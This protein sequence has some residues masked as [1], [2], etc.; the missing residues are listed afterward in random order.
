MSVGL[1]LRKN[2]RQGLA[3]LVIPL[4]AGCQTAPYGG[5]RVSPEYS[6]ALDYTHS[7]GYSPPLPAYHAPHDDTPPVA[8]PEPAPVDPS[9]G[10]GKEPSTLRRDFAVGVASG[11]VGNVVHDGIKRT[12]NRAGARSAAGAASA[13]GE[14]GAAAGEGEA[15][16]FSET[17]I[18]RS[19]IIA[20]RVFFFLPK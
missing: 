9:L 8:N 7:P 17:F 4:L 1:W 6:V 14:A 11:V 20:G 15:V 18:G 5:D 3:L 13:V 2:P 16:A 19:L 12:V 10:S